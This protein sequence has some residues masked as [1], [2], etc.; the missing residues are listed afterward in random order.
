[1]P[2]LPQEL[3]AMSLSKLKNIFRDWSD[4][5]VQFKIRK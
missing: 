5:A 3:F 4:A 2:S 1:M